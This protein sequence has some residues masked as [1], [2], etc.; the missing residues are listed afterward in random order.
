MF[1]RYNT[2]IP[3]QIQTLS[4]RGRFGQVFTVIGAALFFSRRFDE[5]LPK[6]LLAIEDDPSFPQAHRYLA[7]CYA[8]LGRFDEARDAAARLRSITP[9]V[10][11]GATPFR[12]PTH[13]DLLLSG[14]R[15]AAGEAT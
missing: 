8:H 11:A 7:A 4:P 12:N 13:R 5:A 15:L 14:L 3:I 6:L 1:L 10:V 2:T 9:I